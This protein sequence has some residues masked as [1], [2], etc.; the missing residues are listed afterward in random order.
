MGIRRHNAGRAGNR[1][2]RG[3]IS[4]TTDAEL[5]A[6]LKQ[7]PEVRADKVARARELLQDSSYPS[8]SV[9]TKVSDILAGPIQSGD[10]VE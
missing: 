4:D 2:I 8:D 10:A 5:L 7:I 9:L 1:L 3:S 6:V